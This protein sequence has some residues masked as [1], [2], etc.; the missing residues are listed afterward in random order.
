MPPA[1]KFFFFDLKKEERQL[2]KDQLR[3]NLK[4]VGFG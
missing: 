1:L 2:N 4:K 3:V